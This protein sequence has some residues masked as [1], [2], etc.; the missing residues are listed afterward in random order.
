[1][2]LPCIAAVVALASVGLAI[3]QDNGIPPLPPMKGDAASL[4]DT[5]KFLEA[6]L[7]GRV[8]FMIYRHNNTNGSD[9]SIKHADQTSEVNANADQCKIRFHGQM[10]DNDKYRNDYY[11]LNLKQVQHVEV[12]PD[13]QV[14]QRAL[15]KAGHPEFSIRLEPS[16]FSVQS[17]G[18][19]EGPKWGFLFYDEALA[20][21]VATALQ[22][23]VAL[24][25]GG[26]QEPF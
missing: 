12:M 7:P 10:M 24:C 1:M 20:N 6:K 9:L 26:N 3:A 18:G 8:N 16:P 17:T 13:D 5:L 23:A 2:R 15:A 25:G 4:Q 19:W 11:T 14:Y 21:R 22:H